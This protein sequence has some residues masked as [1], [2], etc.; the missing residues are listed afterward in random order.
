MHRSKDKAILKNIPLLLFYKKKIKL[1]EGTSKFT[2]AR[3]L[4]LLHNKLGQDWRNSIS[5]EI[6]NGRRTTDVGQRRTQ[7]NIALVHLS[8]SGDVMKTA[9][10]YPL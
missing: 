6:V 8:V 4:L 2:I 5:K 9:H 10:R 1:G 3:P 7:A